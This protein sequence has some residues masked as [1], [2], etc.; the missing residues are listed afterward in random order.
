MCKWANYEHGSKEFVSTSLSKY[1]SDPLM[2]KPC[3]NENRGFKFFKSLGALSSM[4]SPSVSSEDGL[5]KRVG[6]CSPLKISDRSSTTS[7]AYCSGRRLFKTSVGKL[8]SNEK[9]IPTERQFAQDLGMLEDGS[10]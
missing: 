4:F 5:Q 3:L 9:L 2:Q 7:Q 1:I 8:M 10:A 6:Y